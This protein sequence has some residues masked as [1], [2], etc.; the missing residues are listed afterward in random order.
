M[1]A[2][3]SAKVVA[4]LG[5]A[6]ASPEAIAALFKAGANVFRLNFSHGTHRDHEKNYKSIRKLERETGRPI[7]VLM[8]LQGPKL[9]VGRMRDGLA[10][11]ADGSSFRLDLCE[12]PGDEARAPLLHP[13]VFTALEPGMRLLLNDGA[14]RL[15]VEQSGPDFAETR[16]EVG[17]D[18][19]DNK[20]LNLPNAV[21]DISAMTEKDRKDLEFGLGLGADWVALSFVQ[22]ADDVAEAMAA[23][24]GRAAVLAKLEKPA[25][26]DEL[27]EIVDLADAVMVA[28][29]DLGVEVPPEDVPTLQKRI[30]RA[31]RYAGKPVIVAT[32]MLDSMVHAPVPTRAEASDVAT[33]V[34]DGADAVMLSAETAVGA[35]PVEAVGMMSRIIHRVERDPLYRPLID[36]QRRE[37]QP[38]AEDAITAA[39]RESAHTISAAAIVTFTATGST[40]LRAARE[41]PEVPIISMTTDSRIARRL[42]LAWGVQPIRTRVVNSMTDVAREANRVAV[43]QG[44]AGPGDS[45]VVT[46]GLPFKRPGTTN[47]LR[48]LQVE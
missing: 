19:S 8:D 34:Y 43:E 23:V 10:K 33:A 20:G 36:A 21:L 1:N 48:I 5:P 35:H 7:G 18:L 41:R 3:R 46:A 45:L 30:I 15:R 12:A 42:A 44:I 11:L 13:E 4:T 37:P 16:V 27:Y 14:I 47:I 40:T 29:G 26:I 22:R 6:T 24:D 38:T 31:C 17:G 32:Q 2:F 9:R 28:R 25:A 39:A